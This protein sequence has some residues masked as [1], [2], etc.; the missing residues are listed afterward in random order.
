MHALIKQSALEFLITVY[1]ACN[2]YQVV[3]YIDIPLSEE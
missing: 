1:K 2:N 3:L